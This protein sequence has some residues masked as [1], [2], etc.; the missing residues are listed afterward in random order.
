MGGGGVGRGVVEVVGGRGGGGRRWGE[1]CEVR[2][3]G[4]ESGRG[5]GGGGVWWPSCDVGGKRKIEWM[6]PRKSLATSLPRYFRFWDV[7]S[8]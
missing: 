4:G 6:V 2:G 1:D 5:G 3:G 8:A 7:G